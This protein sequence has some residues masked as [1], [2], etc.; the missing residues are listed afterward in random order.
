MAGGKD[1]PLVLWD[2]E[3]RAPIRRFEAPS[4]EVTAVAF[5]PQGTG[6]A[7]ATI[8]DHAI[9]LFR[10][11]DRQPMKVLQ[12]H[13]DRVRR[14]V[15]LSDG[16]RVLSA[17]DDRTLRLWDLPKGSQLREIRAHRGTISSLDVTTDDQ[18]A[19]SAR[20]DGLCWIWD[21]GTGEHV[22]YF[23]FRQ[24]IEAAA[25]LQGNR[26]VRLLTSD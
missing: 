2:V 25:F 15:F 23:G 5:A 14:I 7:A 22:C 3:K 17:S 10:V 11:S 18:F 26:F 16:K 8:E 9:R 6:I 20:W 12:G 24:P 13:R 4:R 21:L 19:L 1:P